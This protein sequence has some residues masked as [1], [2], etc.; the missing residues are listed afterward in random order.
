MN[1]EKDSFVKSFRLGEELE[2]SSAFAKY[3]CAKKSLIGRAKEEGFDIEL[4]ERDVIGNYI[5]RGVLP[6]VFAEQIFFKFVKREKEEGYASFY[7]DSHQYFD[8]LLGTIKIEA[9]G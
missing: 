9:K 7:I 2:E 5:T 6:P 1:D 3:F 4:Q 8:G